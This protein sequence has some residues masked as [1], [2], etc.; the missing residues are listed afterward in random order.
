MRSSAAV[1]ASAPRAPLPPPLVPGL[2]TTQQRHELFALATEIRFRSRAIVYREAAV[3]SFIFVCAEGVFK[4]YRD[5]PSGKRRVLTFRFKG[6]LFG[7]ADNGRYV[8]TV[9]AVTPAMAYRIPIA[10]LHAKLRQDAELQ[11]RLL[12]RITHEL[13]DAQRQSILLSHRS[14]PGRIAMFL[15]SLQKDLQQSGPA[16]PLPMSRSDIAAYLGLSLEAVSRAMARLVSTGIIATH[17]MHEV[18]VLDQ[19]R[20]DDLANSL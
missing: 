2:L 5:L 14:A 8:N 6:D 4:S 10:Q 16:I 1:V 3:E 18:R 11:F 20:I 7:L 13:R 12:T 15:A 19:T 17:G 9:E